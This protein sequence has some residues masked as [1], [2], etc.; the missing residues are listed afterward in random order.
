MKRKTSIEGYYNILHLD[1]FIFPPSQF[2]FT[3]RNGDPLLLTPYIESGDIETGRDLAR[4]TDP[5][6]DI[7]SAISE[8]YTGFITTDRVNDGNMFFWFFP[9]TVRKSSF[10]VEIMQCWKQFS[11][12]TI[13]S[14]LQK[15][16]Y[17]GRVS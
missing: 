16:V 3:S 8:H 7:G 2:T 11:P 9:A 10:A 13:Q 1:H 12:V 4:V 6:P 15:L 17:L 5:L 14:I